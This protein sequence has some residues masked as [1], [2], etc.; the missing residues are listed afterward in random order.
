MLSTTLPVRWAVAPQELLPIMPPS[1]QFICVAGSGPKRRPYGLRCSLFSTSSTIPGST[2]QVR[3]SASI[4]GTR[5]QYLVQSM[6][7][8]VLVHW[9]ARLVPPPRDSSGA[10]CSRQTATAATAA[11]TVRGSTTP[12]GTWRKF[13]ASVE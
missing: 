4:A 13:D 5:W 10:P 9:P 2:V 8:A 7:T 1:V 6:T 12:M 11:S 3:A